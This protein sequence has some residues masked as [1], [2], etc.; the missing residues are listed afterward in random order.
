MS[1]SQR[2]GDE[3]T[4]AELAVIEAEW[5]V[6]AAELA[7]LDAQIR[8]L[9]VPGGPSPVDWRRLRRAQRR[10]LAAKVRQASHAQDADSTA[11]A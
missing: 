9:S 1:V 2:E 7:V 5:P 8:V 11:V 3:P 6:T 10:L 4:A